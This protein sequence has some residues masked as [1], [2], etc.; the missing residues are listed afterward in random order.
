MQTGHMTID[1]TLADTASWDTTYSPVHL[2]YDPNYE[3]SSDNWLDGVTPQ[4]GWTVGMTAMSGILDS[5]GAVGADAEVHNVMIYGQ[6]G[7]G[8]KSAFLAFDPMAL[9]TVPSYYWIGAYPYNGGLSPLMSALS[10]TRG[11]VSTDQEISLP[12]E[13]ALKGNYP[14]PFNPS[15][16]IVYSI[17]MNSN[18]NVRIFSL[19]G[20]EIATLFNGDVNP[21]NHEVRWNGV[22]KSGAKVA[23]GMYIYRVEANNIALTGKMMLMK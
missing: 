8:G 20:E 19:L 21:G 11:V 16:S 15:T 6:A 5:N 22:D 12:S 18:V 10:W 13:F 7:N 14:N 23:S 3:V 2:N 9:N 4:D 17:G 1:S